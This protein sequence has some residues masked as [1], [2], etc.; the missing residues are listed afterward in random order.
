[1]E[2]GRVDGSVAFRG[3]QISLIR[4]LTVDPT[5]RS[6]ERAV[7]VMGKKHIGSCKYS[8][9]VRS[10]TRIRMSTSVYMGYFSWLTFTILFEYVL[11]SLP[12]GFLSVWR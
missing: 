4:L 2:C 11:D 12:T 10:T 9:Y 7:W 6:T 3:P 1:M 8:G 5:L